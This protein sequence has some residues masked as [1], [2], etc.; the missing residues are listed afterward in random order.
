MKK[1]INKWA[2][3]GGV[4]TALA[5]V[6]TAITNTM[7]IKNYIDEK[8]QAK[9]ETT[10]VGE[11]FTSEEPQFDEEL[12]VKASESYNVNIQDEIVMDNGYQSESDRTT[13]KEIATYHE[14]VEEEQNQDIEYKLK[15]LF[16]TDSDITYFVMKTDNSYIYTC[17]EG[18][19]RYLKTSDGKTLDINLELGYRDQ[20][21]YGYY[22]FY[23]KYNDEMYFWDDGDFYRINDD[24]SFTYLYTDD[25]FC[26]D[27]FYVN[28]MQNGKVFARRTL[29]IYDLNN[30][31]DNY[32]VAVSGSSPDKCF[33]NQLFTIHN[34]SIILKDLQGN[35]ET[36][37]DFVVV[38]KT[39][40]SEEIHIDDYS[41]LAI[42]EDKMYILCK[43]K[44]YVTDCKSNVLE[45]YGIV[46]DK[47]RLDPSAFY[48]FNGKLYLRYSSEVYELVVE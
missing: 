48:E 41:H 5:A 6:T 35:D 47:D 45:E 33:S 11:P 7:D 36:M 30:W 44:I 21:F 43:N 32:K 40:K 4:T 22:L 27:G 31:D 3:I 25:D 17:T 29:K 13:E 46:K 20:Y 9:P 12:G 28:V 26:A 8:I 1:V 34:G 38:Q 19:K 14:V 10:V 18:G 39:G 24:Y 15:R 23:D 37:L 42:G 2:A 16:G